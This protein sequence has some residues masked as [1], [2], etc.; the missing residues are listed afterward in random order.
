VTWDFRT[1]EVPMACPEEGGGRPAVLVVDDEPK[2]LDLVHRT[3]RRTFDVLQAR[4]GNAGLACLETRA[5]SVVV[6]DQRMPGM[7]GVEFLAECS[8]L[9]P[10][11][12]RILLTGY[13]EPEGLIEAINTARVF[14]YLAKPWHPDELLGMVQRAAETSR[15]RRKNARLL[16]GLRRRNRELRVLLEETRRLQQENLRSERW[17]ALGRMAGMVAHDLRSPLAAILCHA[18][19]LQDAVSSDAQAERSAGAIQTQVRNMNGY[20]EDLL[21]CFSGRCGAEPPTRPYEVPALVASLLEAF[22]E[23]CRRRN[24]Q[25]AADL[26]YR[27]TCLVDPPRIYRALENLMANAVD[28]AGDGGIVR[29]ASEDLGDG[30]IVIRIADS[31]PGVPEEIRTVLFDPFVTRG[32]VGGTGLGLAIVRMIVSEHGGR[33]WEEKWGLAGAC[34]HVVLPAGGKRLADSD[35]STGG[36]TDAGDAGSG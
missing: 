20:I 17:A 19:I 15:L 12:E 25:A 1:G 29:V 32:K 16:T 24:I 33:V 9:H 23:R 2:S 4:D 30:Q 26:A 28:A 35:R 27:G 22:S 36:R 14:G 10:E 31:G 6:A 18:G 8:R 34:F 3:L 21:G 11:S 5:V 7:T 13:T